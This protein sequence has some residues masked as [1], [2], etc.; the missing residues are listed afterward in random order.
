MRRSGGSCRMRCTDT[1]PARCS[2]EA[3]A[4]GTMAIAL[5]PAP[6]RRGGLILRCGCWL[7]ALRRGGS[8]CVAIDGG[9]SGTRARLALLSM[10]G[11]APARGTPLPLRAPGRGASSGRPT[12][13]LR[14]LRS[15]LRD[16]APGEYPAPTLQVRE[17]G[18]QRSGGRLAFGGWDSVSGGGGLMSGS[19]LGIRGL[20][21]GI[22]GLG[23]VGALPSSPAPS[24]GAGVDRWSER[25]TV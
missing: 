6:L 9:R 24:G 7:A 14:G 16:S 15:L 11:T 13:P 3:T 23:F 8:A 12:P 25:E 21:F 19:W 10:A 20:G 18:G 5:A 22:R 1:A 17:V 2:W 4:S